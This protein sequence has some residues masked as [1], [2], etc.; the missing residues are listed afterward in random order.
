MSHDKIRGLNDAFRASIITPNPLGK[1]YM[2]A[3]IQTHGEPFGMRTLV[4]IASFDAFTED[5]DPH[6]EHDMIRVVVDDTIVWAKI[7]YYDKADPDLGAEDPS[8]AATTER[9]MTLMLPEEY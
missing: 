1:V 8:N 7:D 9:V 6:G 3:G 2:T 4:A 5:I